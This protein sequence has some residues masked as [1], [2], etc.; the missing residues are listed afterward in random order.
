MEKQSSLY[1]TALRFK[2]HLHTLNL[3]VIDIHRI[4]IYWKIFN[5]LLSYG[6]FMHPFSLKSHYAARCWKWSC[7]DK[8][9]TVM[10]C[11]SVSNKH[12]HNKATHHLLQ[13]AR[14]TMWTLIHMRRPTFVCLCD[15]QDVMAKAARP[16]RFSGEGFITNQRLLLWCWMWI[17]DMTHFLSFI[18]KLPFTSACSVARLNGFHMSASRRSRCCADRRVY[19][20]PWRLSAAEGLLAACC[21]WLSG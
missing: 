20:W 17:Q 7:T 10:H 6:M 12:L 4:L 18:S 5:L 8:N 16:E 3:R 13:S 21:I 19:S 2:K 9:V 11:M 1:G 14:I 15:E